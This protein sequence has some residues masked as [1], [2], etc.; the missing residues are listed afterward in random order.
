MTLYNSKPRKRNERPK[1]R[2]EEIKNRKNLFLFV[3]NMIVDI[4]KPKKF[5]KRVL[6]RISKLNMIT[7]TKSIYK[8]F[9]FI[10]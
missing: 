9:I 1:I 2:K 7:A 6:E 8:Y 10:Y 3:G 4:E 5:T